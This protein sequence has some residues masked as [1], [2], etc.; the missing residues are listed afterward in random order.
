MASGGARNRSG[1]S[2]DL[3][4]KRS[5]ARGLADVYRKLP[6]EGYTGKVP[7]WPFP[8]GDTRERALWRKVWRFPQAV[9]WIEEEWRWLQIAHYVRW[10]VKAE[11]RDASPSTMTQ[12]LR[13]ADAIGLTP[14]GLRENGWI[15]QAGEPETEEA[16]KS[17]QSTPA[18]TRRLR[19]VDGS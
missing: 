17:T 9:A 4:S 3:G 5:D 2:P 12:V 8:K 13:L 18:R 19:A 16:A 10:S 11:A 1:P 7:P 14:A 6:K 15:I